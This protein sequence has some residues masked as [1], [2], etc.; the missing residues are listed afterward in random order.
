VIQ[1]QN[2]IQAFLSPSVASLQAHHLEHATE[3]ILIAVS[4]LVAILGL[5]VSFSIYSKAKAQGEPE[6]ILAVLSRKYYID[7]L[8]DALIAKPFQAVSTRLL[9]PMDNRVLEGLVNGIGSAMVGLGSVLKQ[10]QTGVA[11]NYALVITIGLILLVGYI[12]LT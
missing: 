1:E 11:Q 8:Y 3:W 2:W 12:A 4:S 6:G 10:W 7:E 9:A 5:A